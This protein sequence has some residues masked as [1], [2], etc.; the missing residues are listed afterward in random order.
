MVEA[1][2]DLIF[3]NDTA[4]ALAAHKATDRIPIV[5]WFSGYPVEAGIAE[6]MVRPGKNVTGMSLYAGTGI[7]GKLLELLVETKSETRRVSALWGYVPPAF[8]R[9]EI[10]PCYAELRDAAR[11]LGL[12][13]SIEEVPNPS[14]VSAGIEVVDRSSPDA[15]LITA[16]PGIWDERERIL[17]YAVHRRIPTVSD[18]HW[19]GP[20][21]AL[22][23]LIT[24]GGSISEA[25]HRAARYAERILFEGAKPADLPIQ[26]PAKFDLVVDMRMARAIDLTVPQSILLRADRVIE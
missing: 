5:M 11:T 16:G 7:W 6:S 18:F 19:P 14:H 25:M 1:K 17:R 9:A 26:Q 21:S 8:P 12:S 20:N 13:L 4:H 15:L 2:V 10:E 3:V 22:Q 23:P 24:Y